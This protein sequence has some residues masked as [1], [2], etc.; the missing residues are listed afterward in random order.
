M[1][2]ITHYR[3]RSKGKRLSVVLFLAWSV[4]ITI[5]MSACA[6]MA[7]EN[8]NA[9]MSPVSTMEP[10]AHQ[11][12]S[13]AQATLAAG[14]AQAQNLAIQS[15]Q[16]ALNMT[17]AAATDTYFLRQT[18]RAQ[19][20]SATAQSQ[21]SHRQPRDPSPGPDPHRRDRRNQSGPRDQHGLRHPH[22]HR[23]AANGHAPG[24]HPAGDHRPGGSG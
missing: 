22:R 17:Q 12:H 6:D 13:A 20:E 11:D 16:V 23:L 15:T 14:Q 2:T 5:S 10:G 7:Y 8:A 18:E 1:T 21:Q 9:A 4:L 19:H 3:S 24:G